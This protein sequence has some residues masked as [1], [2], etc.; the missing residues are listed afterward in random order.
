MWFEV[1]TLPTP[2]RWR[3]KLEA[4]ETQRAG[5]CTFVLLLCLLSLYKLQT[6]K[7]SASKEITQ[8]EAKRCGYCVLVGITTA[9][10]AKR[11]SQLT[12]TFYKVYKISIT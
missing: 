8:P 11:H 10:R 2:L 4:L 1:K 6:T 5:I 7:T 3:A 12:Q 9:S